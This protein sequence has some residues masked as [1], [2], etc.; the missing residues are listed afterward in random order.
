M[1]VRRDRLCPAEA[2]PSQAHPL[3][4]AYIP[5]AGPALRHGDTHQSQSPIPL[6]MNKSD[7]NPYRRPVPEASH[8]AHPSWTGWEKSGQGGARGGAR[9]PNRRSNPTTPTLLRN[10]AL[11]V[12]ADTVEPQSCNKQQSPRQKPPTGP[13]WNTIGQVGVGLGD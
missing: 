4:S 5:R 10:R 3:Y 12:I 13:S 6:T 8:L 2:N 1:L 7:R 11:R 9:S